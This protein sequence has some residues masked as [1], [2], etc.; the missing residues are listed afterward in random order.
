MR[1]LQTTFL[2]LAVTTIFVPTM[3]MCMADD[4]TIAVDDRFTQARDRTFQ[5]FNA[6][7][8]QSWQGPFL[9]FSITRYF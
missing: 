1:T 3:G 9:S 2:L 4:R 6:Q 5:T 7:V 8:E